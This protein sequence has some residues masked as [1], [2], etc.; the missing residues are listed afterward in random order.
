MSG[1]LAYRYLPYG[2]VVLRFDFNDLRLLENFDQEQL[3]LFGPRFD[4]TFTDKI[5]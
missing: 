1:E 4:L 5:F 3:F 2:N